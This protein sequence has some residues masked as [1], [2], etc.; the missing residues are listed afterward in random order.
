[1]WNL[2]KK[3][4]ILPQVLVERRKMVGADT[5]ADRKRDALNVPDGCGACHCL[6]GIA[7]HFIMGWRSLW[8][9]PASV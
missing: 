7:G 2:T 4:L 9:I 8:T 5:P 3:L 1:M 6:L